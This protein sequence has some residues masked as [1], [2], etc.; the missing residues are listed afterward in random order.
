[1]EFTSDIE[2]GFTL[3]SLRRR[4]VT[5]MIWMVGPHKGCEKPFSDKLLQPMNPFGL[6]LIKDPNFSS[7]KA[8]RF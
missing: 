3:L 7:Q 5:R 8:G 6:I 2:T 1:M 4:S